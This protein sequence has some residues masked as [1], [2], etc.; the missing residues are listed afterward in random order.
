MLEEPDDEME[1]DSTVTII[2]PSLADL[3]PEMKSW[4]ESED[5]AD[6]SYTEIITIEED[7]TIGDKPVFIIFGPD[8][9]EESRN[10]VHNAGDPYTY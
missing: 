9:V 7:P 2:F 8:G 1:I 10:V 3:S 4:F 6:K 5:E